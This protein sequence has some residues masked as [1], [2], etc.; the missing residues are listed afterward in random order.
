MIFLWARAIYETAKCIV[1]VL[2]QKDPFRRHI[3][4]TKWEKWEEKNPIAKRRL[5]LSAFDAA[6]L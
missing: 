4:H 6:V 1:F 3:R 2:P 5:I